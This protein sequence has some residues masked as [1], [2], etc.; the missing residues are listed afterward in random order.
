MGSNL[1]GITLGANIVRTLVLVLAASCIAAHITGPAQAE[2]P[3]PSRIVVRLDSDVLV[4]MIECPIEEVQAVD[5]VILGVRMIGEAYVTGQPKVKVVDDPNDAAFSVMVTG[6]ISTRTTGRKG[7]VQIYSRSTTQFIATKRVVFQPDHGF[8]GE[9]AEIA[10]RTSSQPERIVP[11]RGGILGRAIERRAWVRAAQSNEQVSQIVQTIAEE[12]IFKA[13]DRLLE[14]HLARVN[15]LAQ[16]RYL[17]AAVRGSL[18]YDCSTMGGWLS[19]AVSSADD[20]SSDSSPALEMMRGRYETLGQDGPA[21]QVW[22]HEQ[23]LGEPLAMLIRR[24]DSARQFLGQLIVAMQ[25][26]ANPKVALW[27]Q[28]SSER[29]YD[30]SIIDTWFVVHSGPWR[31]M[32]LSVG[33]TA[34][35]TSAPP[36]TILRTGNE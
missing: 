29:S 6:T 30:F 33:A 13:F 25:V 31:R 2:D 34:N 27:S 12:K 8:I 21:I 32:K 35:A 22:V 26:S 14:A 20:S 10:A 7:P 15:W 16:Q 28:P 3:L 9:K 1:Q 4:P 17:A 36:P 18:R 23:V 19:I 24:V 5:E 11:I